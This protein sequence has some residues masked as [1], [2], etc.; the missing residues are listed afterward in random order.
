MREEIP[1]S[2]DSPAV[3]TEAQ[4]NTIFAEV[5]QMIF[6]ALQTINIRTGDSELEVRSSHQGV[7]LSTNQNSG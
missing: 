2:T 4:A 5:N 1:I 7:V 3:D 6:D